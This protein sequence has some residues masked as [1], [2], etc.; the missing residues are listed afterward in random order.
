MYISAFLHRD[1]LF[2]ITNRWL[3]DDLE[4]GDPLRVTRI[5]TYDSFAAWEKLLSFV[6]DLNHALCPVPIHQTPIS[7]KKELKDFICRAEGAKSDRT[8]QLISDYLS[9][10]E[11]HYIGSPLAGYIYHDNN[12]QVISMCRLKRVKRIAEKTSRY[13]ALYITQKIQE[14]ADKL[15]LTGDNSLNDI[16]SMSNDILARAEKVL[17]MS[18]K[19]NGLT[20][21]IDIMTIKDVL[22]IKVIRNGV[23]ENKLESVIQRFPE[24]SIIEKEVHSGNYNAVHYIIELKVDFENIIQQFKAKHDRAMFD[25]RGLPEK[26]LFKDFEAFV[27]TGSDTVQ[28][29]LIL[30]TFDELIESEIGRSM[31]EARIFKQRRH[32]NSFG[33]IP[34]NIEYLIEYLL[35]VGLSPVVHIDRIPIKIFKCISTFYFIKCYL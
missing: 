17:M 7:V 13:A 12:N 35:A 31:H 10:P 20:L 23:S 9:L 5:I 34:I 11:Y 26:Q 6:S 19:N 27:R 33:N 22:G 15:P 30:T 32:Q 14:T 8:R 4:P 18:I 28:V 2:E 1:E 3:S 21:P 29:D 24:A 25:N 16:K